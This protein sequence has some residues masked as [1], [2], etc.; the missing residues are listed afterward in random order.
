MSDAPS[1]TPEKGVAGELAQDRVVG[2]KD[3]STWY[4]PFG[5]RLAALAERIGAWIGPRATLVLTLVV[6]MVAVI[7]L[8]AAAA[9]VY[10]AVTEADGVAGLDEP[11]LDAAISIREPWLNVAATAFTDVAGVT[12]MP[13]IAVTVMVLLALRRSSW[14]PVIL[15]VAAGVGSLLM[16]IVGKRLIGRTR[17]SLADAVPPFEH[18]PSFPSGHT[19]NAV[20]IA[21]IIAYLLVLRR[22]HQASRIAIITVAFAFAATVAATRVYLG[23]HWFTD[24]LAAFCLGLAWLALVITAHRLYLTIRKSRARAGVEDPDAVAAAEGA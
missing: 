4:T 14:T 18:S 5:R 9:Q 1:G 23:H 17:P 19:L 10:E 13:I 20:V 6:G 21:G 15:I 2:G 16:T 8:S 7:T 12:I 3:L 22:K 11:M 24:V